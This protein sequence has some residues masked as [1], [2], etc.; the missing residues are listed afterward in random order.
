MITIMTVD[1]FMPV[2]TTPPARPAA[3]TDAK[4]TISRR[5]HLRHVRR[6]LA[7]D[8]RRHGQRHAGDQGRRSRAVRRHQRQRDSDRDVDRHDDASHLLRAGDD[9][10][11]FT[12]TSRTR[13]RGRARRPLALRSNTIRSAPLTG[14]CRRPAA[15]AVAD[16]RRRA[17][18]AVPGA[19]DHLLRRQHDDAGHA[20][21]HAAWSNNFTPQALA[22]VVEDLDLTYDLFDGVN[23]PTQS[24]ALPVHAQRRSPTPRTRF[25]RSTSTSACGPRRSPSRRRTTS[26]TTSRR[27]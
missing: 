16:P 22:G 17:G 25:G 26:A 11:S 7:V 9:Y 24:P 4:A 1:E 13:P 18:D 14:D 3:P 12:S 19:D 20:A 5:R 10:D 15:V 27:R 2:V 8:R 21:A 23:N 6:D